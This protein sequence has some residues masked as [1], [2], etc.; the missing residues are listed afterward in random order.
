MVPC[1]VCGKGAMSYPSRPR[2]YC[3]MTCRDIASRTGP[4]VELACLGCGGRYRVL[5]SRAKRSNYCSRSCS[6]LN[7]RPRRPTA[8]DGTTSVNHSGYIVEKVPVGHWAA[9][10]RT[11]RALQH[12]LVM[13][14]K[15]GRPL[16]WNENVHHINGRKTDNRPGNLE[17]WVKK[18]P[19]GQRASDMLTWAREI[20][21]TYG[22]IADRL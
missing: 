17:L 19:P 1:E 13:A 16:L 10:G 22:P 7:R 20:V 2:K 6:A 11:G 8:A 14:V 21:A 12:R 15:L 3:S 9:Q 5:P 18:Q 4:S